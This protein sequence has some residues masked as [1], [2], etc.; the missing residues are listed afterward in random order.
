MKGLTKEFLPALDDSADLTDGE[1]GSA[2]TT[3]SRE[4]LATLLKEALYREPQYTVST[5]E[6]RRLRPHLYIRGRLV[7]SEGPAKVLVYR[8]DWLQN[9]S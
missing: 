8:V 1:A 5:L 4:H 6:V 7:C 9:A 2:T 3:T